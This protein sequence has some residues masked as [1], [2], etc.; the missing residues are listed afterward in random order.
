MRKVVST[1]DG[2]SSI[3]LL[4]TQEQYHSG[5]GAIQEAK[6]VYINAGL[7]Y[8][9][10]QG[11]SSISIFEM[12]FGTGLNCFLSYLEAVDLNLPLQYTC[13][14]AFPIQWEEVKM[15]NYAH[16]LQAN[17][18]DFHQLHKLPWEKV[19]T[20]HAYFQFYKQ[21][22]TFQDYHPKKLY[23]LVYYDAFGART[24]PELWTKEITDQLFAMLKVHGVVV[25]FSV[26]GSFRRNLL[27]SGFFVEKLKGPAGKRE[28]LR[29]IKLPC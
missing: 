8:V 18:S 20:L 28:M 12:G 5:H 15:L 13:I 11:K 24:Q 14:E 7:R 21:Q 16:Q 29:A 6:H 4:D 17:L 10:Q 1:A 22:T 27:D 19:H 9:A 26:L 3:L 23:D 25:T 2:S